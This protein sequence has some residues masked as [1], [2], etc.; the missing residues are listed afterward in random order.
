M[1]LLSLVRSRLRRYGPRVALVGGVGLVGLAP[2]ADGDI[3]WHLAAGREMVARGSFLFTDPFSVSAA[4]RPWPDVHWLFQL[5]AY[6]VHS[7][8]GLAGLVW[9]KCAL[10][11]A[12][13]IVL[14]AA[15]GRRA[16]ADGSHTTFVTLLVAALFSARSLLLLR[17]VLITL[18]FLALFLLVLETVGRGGKLA[19]LWALPALQGLCGDF[20]RPPALGPGVVAAYGVAAGAA[21][22]RDGKAWAF[23]AEGSPSLPTRRLATGLL[24]ALVGCGVACG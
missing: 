19:W 13:S 16:V 9:A 3:W 23:A 6:A 14:G 1:R 2:S 4:G 11:V 17:P 24:L 18:L 15:L 20:A 12:S 8:F 21:A 10:L 7:S 22:V 5:V